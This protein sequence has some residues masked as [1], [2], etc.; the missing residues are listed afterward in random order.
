MPRRGTVP[1][2]TVPKLSHGRQTEIKRRHVLDN[3]PF[4]CQATDI[5]G[6]PRDEVR[7]K[8]ERRI[9]VETTRIRRLKCWC[10]SG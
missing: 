8:L 1:Y 9:V 6:G 4:V 7:R 10:A 3:C 2:V 5:L